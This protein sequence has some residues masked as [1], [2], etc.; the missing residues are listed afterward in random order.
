M[1]TASCRSCIQDSKH[2]AGQSLP[3][4]RPRRI[5]CGHAGAQAGQARLCRNAHCSPGHAMPAHAGTRHQA[6][7]NVSTNMWQTLHRAVLTSFLSFTSVTHQQ[8]NGSHS[9]AQDCMY[10][11]K[12]RAAARLRATQDTTATTSPPPP[13]NVT[14]AQAVGT[15][16]HPCIN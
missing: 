10:K 3:A 5:V 4:C 2:S 6:A 9:T 12:T 15:H 13:P 14:T 1:E 11:V 7:A 16:H 8:E